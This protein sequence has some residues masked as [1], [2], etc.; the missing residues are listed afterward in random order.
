MEAE[1]GLDLVEVPL[2]R[3]HH[4][5]NT[6]SNRQPPQEVDFGQVVVVSYR[7]VYRR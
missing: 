3:L 6:H 5:R 2:H 1:E 7:V 4:T